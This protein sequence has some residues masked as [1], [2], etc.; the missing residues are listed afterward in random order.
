M[1][2]IY[3]RKKYNDFNFRY[4]KKVRKIMEMIISATY[5]T[6][7]IECR[8]CSVKGYFNTNT[9]CIDTQPRL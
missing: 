3:V 9:I 5:F 7:R 2:K 1:L 4:Q 8:Q 6:L